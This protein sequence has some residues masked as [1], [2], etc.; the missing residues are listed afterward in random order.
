M[1][2]SGVFPPDLVSAM[3]PAPGTWALAAVFS[4][5]SANMNHLRLATAKPHH[6]QVSS[7][8][9]AFVI[10]SLIDDRLLV[11][12]QTRWERLQIVNAIVAVL[13]IG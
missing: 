4:D 13:E 11:F 10:N 9:P 6:S 8:P 5:L 3:D 1:E 2:G 12:G 7:L